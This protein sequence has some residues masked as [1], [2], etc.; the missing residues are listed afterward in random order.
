MSQLGRFRT[1][2]RILISG[3]FVLALVLAWM[4]AAQADWIPTASLSSSP[5]SAYRGEGTTF[6]YTL[7]NG[8]DEGLDI[9][10]VW[11]RYCWQQQGEG[12]DLISDTVTISAWGSHTFTKHLTVPEQTSGMCKCEVEIEGKAVGDPSSTTGTW[13]PSFNTKQREPLNAH[14]TGDPT[15]GDEPLTVSFSTTVSGGTPGYSYSWTFGDGS[16]SSSESPSHT[17][18]S[19]GTYT[20]EVVVTDSMG[21]TDSDTVNIHVTTATSGGNGGNGGNDP[22]G[23]GETDLGGSDTSLMVML[24]LV[25]AAVVAIIFASAIVL[26][27]KK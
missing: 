9:T 5:S 14:A 17:Y 7:Y 11:V 10:E 3:L 25:L 18:D 16:S 15:S 8:Q 24:L 23:T 6:S 2:R 19:A 22:G 1:E 13:K 27:R 4:P 21:R 20:A 12:Y 26:S